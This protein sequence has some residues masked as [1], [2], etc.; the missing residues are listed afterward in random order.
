MAFIKP[1]H[2]DIEALQ[3]EMEDA[4]MIDANPGDIKEFPEAKKCMREILK[5]RR[6][7]NK[8]IKLTQGVLHND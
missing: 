1:R 3:N 5:S 2:S 4:F 6:R 8:I 7:V